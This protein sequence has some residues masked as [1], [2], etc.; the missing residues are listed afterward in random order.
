METLSSRAVWQSRVSNSEF[1]I[2]TTHL[3]ILIAQK[4]AIHPTII[5]LG[6]VKTRQL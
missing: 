3:P 1:R 4:Y 6:V 2:L 5:D